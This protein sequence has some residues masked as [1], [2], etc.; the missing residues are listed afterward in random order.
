MLTLPLCSLPKICFLQIQ[1]SLALTMFLFSVE[2]SSHQA[3]IPSLAPL[4]VFP[5]HMLQEV[6]KGPAPHILPT[7]SPV[8]LQQLWQTGALYTLPCVSTYNPYT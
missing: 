8:L 5:I 2:A 7:T 1:G 6:D 4:A 3:L